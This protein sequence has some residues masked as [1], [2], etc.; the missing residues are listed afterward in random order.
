M[1]SIVTGGEALPVEERIGTLQR[2]KDE[3]RPRMT[4]KFF[5]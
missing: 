1:N 2:E 3:T 5:W 4:K